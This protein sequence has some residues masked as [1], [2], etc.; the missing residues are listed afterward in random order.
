MAFN[1]K[2]KN[3]YASKQEQLNFPKNHFNKTQQ[4]F[5]KLFSYAVKPVS[6]WAKFKSS[7]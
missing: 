7:L 4:F 2:A 3:C 5:G 1:S 6:C